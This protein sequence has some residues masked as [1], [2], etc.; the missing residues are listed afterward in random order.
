MKLSYLPLLALAF[1]GISAENVLAQDTPKGITILSYNHVGLAV[2][3]LKVS[4][5]FTS[6]ATLI[7]LIGSIALTSF[8]LVSP[9]SKYQIQILELA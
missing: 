7:V 6:Q 8:S 2:K 1:A 9:S 5:A 3:D 4:A